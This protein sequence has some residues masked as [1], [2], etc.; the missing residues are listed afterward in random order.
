MNLQHCLLSVPYLTKT[1]HRDKTTLCSTM[2]C[3]K[4]KKLCRGLLYLS[5]LLWLGVFTYYRIV[6]HSVEDS[7]GSREVIEDDLESLFESEEDEE[8]EEP[9]WATFD[10]N[11]VGFERDIFFVES[12]GSLGLTARQGCVVEAA[13]TNHPF[14][15]IWVLFTGGNVSSINV[16]D[17]GIPNSANL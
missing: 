6:R 8:V 1:I 7:A 15:N 14:R 5:V 10:P 17:S 13:A 4:Y 9:L 16:F 2:Q 11:E 3:N 12:S